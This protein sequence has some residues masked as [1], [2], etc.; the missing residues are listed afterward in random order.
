MLKSFVLFQRR[1]EN[2]KRR[3]RAI[4]QYEDEDDITDPSVARKSIAPSSV[5]L[6]TI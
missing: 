1:N 4:I 2:H 6:Q 3:L 5:P